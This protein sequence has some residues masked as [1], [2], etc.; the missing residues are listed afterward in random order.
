VSII[1]FLR[2]LWARRWIV[3]ATAVSCVIGAL[4]VVLVVP[5]RWQAHSRVMLDMIK[6]DPLTGEVIGV[7]AHPYAATQIELVKDYAVAGQVA[8]QLGWLS[9]PTLI[10]K[11]QHRPASDQSDFRRWLAQLVID[12]TDA[13]LVEGSNILEITYTGA[14]PDEAKAVADAL[15]KAYIDTSVA[16]RRQ[17]A[18]RDA[19]WFDNQAQKAKDALDAAAA[20]EA[21][22]EKQTGLML[23]DDKTD[24]DTARLRAL[25][26]AAGSSAQ[27]IAPMGGG[28]GGAGAELAQ[29]DAAISQASQTLGPNHP[30]L[31]ALRAKR[32]ALVAQEAQERSFARESAGAAASAASAGVG[33]VNQAMAAEK[34]KIMGQA[35][36]IE[37]LKELQAEVELRRD[38]YNKTAA[39]A[40]DLR[41][42]ATIG[43]TGLTVLGS[44]VTPQHPAFPNKPLIFGG[45]IG[46]GVAMGVLVALLLELFGRRVRGAEDLNSISG[47]V[48][49]IVPVTLAQR[50]A[51]ARD[52]RVGRKLRPS[53]R[54]RVVQA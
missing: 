47:P 44:A 50:Q 24:V 49:A 28:G 21:V 48:L 15:M 45:S 9:D 32:A 12:R 31:V 2:I 54:P 8:D 29:V 43:E 3:V 30:Q 17:A 19:D 25:A 36:K 7:N 39:K 26:G 14:K 34:T 40:A 35:D 10:G 16:I 11:Y 51:G 18:A 53:A 37:K 23:Q 13:E 4:I 1:Q 6:P 5:P 41:Q 46:L 33:A 52:R 20:A 42:E 22:Y 27:V 38:E